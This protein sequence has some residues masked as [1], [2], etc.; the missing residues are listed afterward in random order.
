MHS[1]VAQS[2]MRGYSEWPDDDYTDVV[3]DVMLDL[4]QARQRAVELGVRREH[5]W[6]DPGFGFSKN[7]RHC[8]E[9]LAR[10][11]EFSALGAPIV[12]GPGRKSFIA[13]ADPSPPGARLGGT[14]AASLEAERRGA[15]VLR[16]HDVFEVRQA[17]RV[18]AMLAAREKT[19]FEPSEEVAP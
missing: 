5:I 17:L 2:Q 9:C 12:V 13:A 15:A 4:E 18:G 10:L 11:D 16:I 7:A 19:T 3:R 14:I 6:F 1:R 8:F